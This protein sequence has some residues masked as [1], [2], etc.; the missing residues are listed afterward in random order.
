[1]SSLR[2]AATVT[3]LIV[4]VLGFYYSLIT[5]N[6]LIAFTAAVIGFMFIFL[7]Q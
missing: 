3:G 6:Y 7:S 1:M 2:L 4:I 5:G